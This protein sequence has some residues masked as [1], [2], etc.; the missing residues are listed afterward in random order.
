MNVFYLIVTLGFKIVKGSKGMHSKL[1]SDEDK[2]SFCGD[3]E[4]LASLP[5]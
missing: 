2:Q 4:E 1:N 5:V 3:P